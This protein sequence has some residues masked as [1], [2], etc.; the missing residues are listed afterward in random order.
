MTSCKD[1]LKV[2]KIETTFYS[3][4]KSISHLGKMARTSAKSEKLIALVSENHTRLLLTSHTSK[5]YIMRN[6]Y[7]LYEV[8]RSH[9]FYLKRVVEQ[10]ESRLF[11]IVFSVT[12]ITMTK[13]FVITA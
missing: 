8:K 6:C 10:K 9:L 3:I 1:L 5:C 11:K 7:F 2:K 12:W 13:I 4:M